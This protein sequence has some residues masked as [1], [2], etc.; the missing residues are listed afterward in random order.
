MQAMKARQKR[1]R[2]ETIYEAP[3]VLW[4]R[5]PTEDPHVWVHRLSFDDRRL[6]FV[7]DHEGRSCREI[8]SDEPCYRVVEIAF[9]VTLAIG[10]HNG[11]SVKA[12]KV[13]PKPG[14]R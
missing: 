5:M 3:G 14:V 13:G 7:T 12:R 6:F 8:R 4:E 11:G 1:T 10:R 9:P 2:R